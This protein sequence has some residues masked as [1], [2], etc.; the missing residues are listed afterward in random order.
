MR[1][2]ISKKAENKKRK[3]N[4]FIVGGILVFIM[5]FS[6]V[7]YGFS[8][9]EESNKEIKYNGIKFIQQNDFWFTQIENLNFGF[10][11]S[12]E[13]TE[14]IL[15]ETNLKS[16]EN[17]NLKPLYFSSDNLESTQEIYR[18]LNQIVQR[19]LEACL[20]EEEC[21]GDFPIKT[22]EDNFIIIR[23]NNNSKITQDNNCVFIQGPKE[24]L[25]KITDE[26][27]F[28]IMNIK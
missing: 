21:D 6:V 8:P 17:Y 25:V 7:G 26:F 22:C 23:E 14:S 27:L 1:K 16:I 12:P 13:E 2:I 9:K 3:R 19:M 28:K 18:N 5:L 15:L 20:N 10:K 4:Q 24:E 11:Y